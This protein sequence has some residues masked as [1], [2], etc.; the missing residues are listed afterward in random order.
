MPLWFPGFLPSAPR[1][2]LLPGRGKPENPEAAPLHSTGHT[3][4]PPRA[5]PLL[6]FFFLMA[7]EPQGLRSLTSNR[8][9]A[10]V[11]KAPRPNRCAA[12]EDPNAP[13]CLGSVGPAC[14]H[15]GR[16]AFAVFRPPPEPFPTAKLTEGS[17]YRSMGLGAGRAASPSGAGGA[18]QASSLWR[19]RAF[20][21]I[22]RSVDSEE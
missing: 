14:I 21:P 17:A 19:T 5:L 11:V 9:Q 1:N 3:W 8:T 16:T 2:R 6:P 15:P 20:T 13:L 12:R 4:V 18:L 7:T 10:V 22:Q